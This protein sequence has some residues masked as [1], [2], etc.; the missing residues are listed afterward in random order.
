[1]TDDQTRA[2]ATRLLDLHRA[3]ELLT[4]VNVWDVISATVVAD[5][6]GTEALATASHS[7]AASYGYADG[8][9]ITDLRGYSHP[10]IGVDPEPVRRPELCARAAR[11]GSDGRAYLLK[12]RVHNRARARSLRSGPLPTAAR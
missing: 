8:E 10:E 6:P 3:P 9:N 12:E 2:R 7:I 5:V 11:V 1:M 4:V